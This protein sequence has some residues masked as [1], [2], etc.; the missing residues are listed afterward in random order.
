LLSLPGSGRCHLADEVQLAGGTPP[1]FARRNFRPEFLVKGIGFFCELRG[2]QKLRELQHSLG[3]AFRGVTRL[4]LQVLLH[5][6][7]TDEAIS[8]KRP[9]SF[10]N[11]FGRHGVTG[12]WSPFLPYPSLASV[13]WTSAIGNYF[14]CFPQLNQSNLR[15]CSSRNLST[16]DRASRVL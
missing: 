5:T 4:A 2:R 12:P 11:T 13:S 15:I 3:E 10:V 14:R 7:G 8:A 9:Q 6:L 16:S 1:L